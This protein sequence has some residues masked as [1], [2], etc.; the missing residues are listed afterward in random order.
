MA[1]PM[2]E[3]RREAEA[4]A[5]DNRLRKLVEPLGG[6]ASVRAL[7]VRHRA[8]A[9]LT[10][11]LGRISVGLDCEHQTQPQRRRPSCIAG[12]ACG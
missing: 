2:E 7:R 9:V 6:A 11:T 10:S 12:A 4:D 1:D 8:G 3:A 5:A